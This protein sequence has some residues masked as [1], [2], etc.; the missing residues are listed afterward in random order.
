MRAWR[1]KDYPRR[2]KVKDTY[3]RI[4]FVRQVPG[5]AK[6]ELAGCCCSSTKTIW[7]TLGQSPEERAKTVAHELSHALD[8]EYGLKLPHRLIYRLE[9]PLVDLFTS[10]E[11][12]SA[13][14][15]KVGD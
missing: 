15:G 10:L 5:D 12:G 2:V 1:I 4:L 6:R 8:W 11:L 7:I 9:A 13:A 14:S 3:Y